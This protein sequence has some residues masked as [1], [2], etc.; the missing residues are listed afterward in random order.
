MVFLVSEKSEKK[1]MGQKQ[2]THPSEAV[3]FYNE[4]A[5][6]CEDCLSMF[7]SRAGDFDKRDM[8]LTLLT[9]K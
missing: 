7:I 8:S 9:K 4:V 2:R 5:L 6:G 3:L 1:R